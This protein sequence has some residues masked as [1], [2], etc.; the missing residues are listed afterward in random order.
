MIIVALQMFED[1]QQYNWFLQTKFHLCRD[2]SHLASK[3]TDWRRAIRLRSLSLYPRRV[4]GTFFYFLVVVVVDRK[5]L[6]FFSKLEVDRYEL[7]VF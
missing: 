7:L 3:L 4:L 6:S 1:D 2:W 5:S